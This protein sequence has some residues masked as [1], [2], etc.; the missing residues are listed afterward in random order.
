MKPGNQLCSNCFKTAGSLKSKE[1]R[2]TFE[3]TV[4]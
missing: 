2:E 4:K 3:F 1:N